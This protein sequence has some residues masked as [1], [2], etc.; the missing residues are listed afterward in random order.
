MFGMVENGTLP[1]FNYICSSLKS[2]VGILGVVEIVGLE[3]KI[4]KM[5]TECVLKF[6]ISSVFTSDNQCPEISYFG[7]FT[8]INAIAS[9]NISY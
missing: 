4:L 3:L 9:Y 1:G 2:E 7:P 6:F 8:N 5:K